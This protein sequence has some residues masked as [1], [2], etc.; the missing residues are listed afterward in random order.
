M[1]LTVSSGA[2]NGIASSKIK[3]L[4]TSVLHSR[5]AALVPTT[6]S[7]LTLTGHTV[8]QQPPAVPDHLGAHNGQERLPV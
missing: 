1:A 8:A 6:G 5:L 4:G 3:A 7:T 2:V